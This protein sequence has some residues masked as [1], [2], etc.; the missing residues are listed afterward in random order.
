MGQSAN[1]HNFPLENLI[2]A[3]SPF[4]WPIFEDVKLNPP[5]ALNTGYHM[6][7]TALTASRDGV[8]NGVLTFIQLQVS[9]NGTLLNS[10]PDPCYGNTHWANKYIPLD[11]PVSV[12]AGDTLY[13]SGQSDLTSVNSKYTFQVHKPRAGLLSSL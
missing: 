11:K 10:C 2:C 3:D 4:D 5:K 12:R 1:L 8:V 7:P 6:E 9:P 13:L